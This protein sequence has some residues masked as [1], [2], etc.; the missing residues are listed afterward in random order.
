M[1]V[2]LCRTCE[3]IVYNRMVKLRG[4]TADIKFQFQ[5]MLDESKNKSEEKVVYVLEEKE[6]YG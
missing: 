1:D 3:Q 5:K 6:T 4:D 2:N